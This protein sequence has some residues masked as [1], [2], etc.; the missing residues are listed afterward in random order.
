[1]KIT[2]IFSFLVRPEKGQEVQSEVGGT[3][4]PLEG[5]L[6]YM[7]LT[8][9]ERATE[10]CKIDIT[11]LPS[12]DGI[13]FNQRR[14]EIL[15]VIKH[16]D[17]KHAQLLAKHLQSVTTKRSKLG[18]FFIVL[19]RDGG[20]ERIYLSRFPA[21]FG[22]VA[23]ETQNELHVELIEQVFMKSEKSYKAVVFDGTNAD[24][25]F[26]IGKAI[27]KQVNDNSVSISG[28][29]IKEFLKADFRTT[30]AAGTRRLAKAI[31]ETINQTNDL[32]IK[33]ELTSAARLSRSLANKIIS[34]DNFADKF[35]LS[36]KTKNALI[37]TLRNRNLRF[38]QFKF[39][40][41]EFRKHVRFRSLQISNG[42]ILTAPLNSFD[43]CFTKQC[44]A[45]DSD[46][47]LF[48]TQGTIV[49][50]R[51]RAKKS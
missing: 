30:S 49:D 4:I 22:I 12:G 13:Q 11:F 33:E 16:R 5:N 9:F 26:W 1:M 45:D 2:H 10:D 39:S 51:L 29:W 34:M 17:I 7:L 47:Y 14:S 31:M 48:S 36:E 28:Y 21:D 8:I 42:A 15:D 41:S 50:D 19:G 32:E 20:T 24:S 35:G 3:S 40:T 44:I 23:E 27:D 37:S 43:Q 38:D 6:Y 25:D 46:E 18:L